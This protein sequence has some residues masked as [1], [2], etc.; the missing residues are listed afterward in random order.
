M[1]SL[2]ATDMLI[3]GEDLG[4]VPDCVPGDGCF[5]IT[6]FKVQRSPKE[7]VPFYNPQN[8]GYMNVVMASLMTVLH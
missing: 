5:G 1:L 4:L 2:A 6:A 8:A 3:C 7:D